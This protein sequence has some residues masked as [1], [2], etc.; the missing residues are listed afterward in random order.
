[1]VSPI[2][3][4]KSICRGTGTLVVDAGADTA[5]EAARRI[6]DYLEGSPAYRMQRRVHSLYNMAHQFGKMGWR[7]S[8]GPCAPCRIGAQTTN[9]FS[10]RRI[11]DQF[12]D[13]VHNGLDAFEVFFD[14]QPERHL[15]FDVEDLREDI[16][17]WLRDRA[18]E[19][20]VSLSVYARRHL[21]GPA[22]RRRHWAECLTF[23][24]DIAAA[25]LVIDLPPPEAFQSGEFNL[26]VDDL[27]RLTDFASAYHLQVAVENGSWEASGARTFTSAEQ[28]NDA[29]ARLGEHGNAAGVSFNAGRAHLLED[30]LIY[31]RKIHPPVCHVKLSDN[32]GRGHSEVHLRLGEGTVPWEGVL[33]ELKRVGYRGAIILEYFHA[34]LSR[35]RA[36]IE[37]ALSDR[38]RH[39]DN[40]P[41]AHVLRNGG[42][43]G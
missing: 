12:L 36:M 40:S 32:P 4:L 15:G 6:I 25:L 31:L 20:D 30:P 13:S 27:Q 10:R 16:R 8:A 38:G 14:P 24:N 35:E 3:P 37:A 39:P 43:R 1:V 23:A 26:F 9:Y 2:P 28:L 22:D 41:A 33:E 18:R 34:D 11:E 21:H 42:E 5:D 19:Q 17:H 29:F 7:L